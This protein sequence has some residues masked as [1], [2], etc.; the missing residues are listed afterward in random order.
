MKEEKPPR[1]LRHLTCAIAVQKVDSQ[2]FPEEIVERTRDKLRLAL[3]AGGCGDGLPQE[4]DVVQAFEVRLIQSLLK[5]CRDPDHYFGE[6][7]ARG[8][9]LGS[10]SR[11]LPRTPSVF[12][13][14]TKWKF[15]ESTEE[16]GG[17]WQQNYSSL[18][19]HASLVQAQ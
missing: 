17:E 8:V 6:W 15:H 16:G 13:R 18:V 7:W 10:P 11:K 4:G 1:D 2:P 3:K 5:G 12:D 14:K 19:D 9:W